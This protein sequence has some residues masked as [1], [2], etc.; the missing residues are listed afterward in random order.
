MN[1][2]GQFVRGVIEA[3]PDMV[4]TALGALFVWGLTTLSNRMSNSHARKMLKVQLDHD[5][6]ERQRER[7]ATMKREVLLPALDAGAQCM[8]LVAQLS[9]PEASQSKIDDGLIV[10]GQK[11]GK[12]AAMCSAETWEILGRLQHAIWELQ[13]DMSFLRVPMLAAHASAVYA[14]EQAQVAVRE[15]EKSNAD[16]RQAHADRGFQSGDTAKADRALA[17]ANVYLAAMTARDREAS[18]QLVAIQI[19]MLEKLEDQYSR[20]SDLN[21]DAILALRFEL[22][23]E[24]DADEIKEARK[25]LLAEHQ[26]IVGSMLERLKSVHAEHGGQPA[27]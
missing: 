14:R 3:M 18:L 19:A 11:L 23:F 22:G 10:A 1:P 24:W 17:I 27:S 25:R 16:Q 6:T 4:W 15:M 8:T 2:V 5:S 7:K 20:L 13:S 21:L 12:A 26:R 9:N